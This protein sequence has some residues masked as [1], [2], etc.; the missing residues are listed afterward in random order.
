MLPNSTLPGIGIDH[1]LYRNFNQ[2]LDLSKLESQITASILL[3]AGNMVSNIQG[4]Y[5]FFQRIALKAS[6]YC[7]SSFFIPVVRLILTNFY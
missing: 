5:A 2:H 1:I 4:L 7:N 6:S 3:L